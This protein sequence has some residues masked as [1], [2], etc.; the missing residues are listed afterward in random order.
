VS[1][2]AQGILTAVLSRGRRL[3]A[4]AL[5]LAAAAGLAAFAGWAMR[6]YP[7]GPRQPVPFSHLRHAGIRDV[8]CYF[9]HDGADRSPVA[10]MPALDKCLLCHNRV[11]PQFGPVRQLHEAYDSGRPVAWVRV[12]RLPE[13]AHFNH[14]AHI[15]KRIDCGQCHGN[16]KAMNRIVLNQRLKMAWCVDCHKRPEYKAS[17]DCW[18]CHR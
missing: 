15:L 14:E 12:Y 11:A 5:W 1:E 7:T 16:V 6:L 8:S 13:Y 4:A 2:R 3:A 17:V 9:C 18:T 10:G